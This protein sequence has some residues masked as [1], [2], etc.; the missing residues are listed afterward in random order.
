MELPDPFIKVRAAESLSHLVAEL[1]EYL[2]LNDFSTINESLSQRAQELEDNQRFLSQ[3]IQA[4]F[5]AYRENQLKLINN[6]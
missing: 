1:K 3:E 2:I 4:M 5:E 6:S